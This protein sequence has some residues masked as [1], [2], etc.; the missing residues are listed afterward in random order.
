VTSSHVLIKAA[1]LCLSEHWPRSLSLEELH[2]LT[3]VKLHAKPDPVQQLQ[4]AELLAKAIVRCY[5]TDLVQFHLHGLHEIREISE[6]PL[7]GPL[8]RWQAIRREPIS[9]L[10][11]ELVDLSD[12][13]RFVLSLLDG[14]RDRASIIQAMI[15]HVKRGE[16]TLQQK[17]V[18]VENPELIATV[19]EH[20]LSKTFERFIDM[21]LLQG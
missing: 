16:I 12:F 11:H 1:L 10:A 9:N 15:E 6:R 3:K 19:V 2:E 17:G 13:D 21:S 8:S 4:D 20:T 18:P 7:A 14:T 5:R